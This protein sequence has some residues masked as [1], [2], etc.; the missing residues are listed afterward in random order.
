MASARGEARA[1]PRERALASPAALLRGAPPVKK[2]SPRVAEGPR[3]RRV[4]DA[5][6]GASF[7]ADA[8]ANAM[9][10]RGCRA[11]PAAYDTKNGS[12]TGGNRRLA[13][14]AKGKELLG[15][16]HP[17]VAEIASEPDDLWSHLC[18]RVGNR[19]F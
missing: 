17:P 11:S 3:R 2:C 6:G 9:F 18:E 12:P 16:R 13:T 15:L 1:R 4:A 8:T 14:V 7:P 5:A 10:V 19:D